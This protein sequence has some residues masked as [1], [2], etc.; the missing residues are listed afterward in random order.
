MTIVRGVARRHNVV[1]EGGDVSQWWS[2]EPIARRAVELL[3]V[4]PGDRVLDLGA[5]TGALSRAVIAA[6][7][8]VTAVELDPKFEDELRAV[9]GDRGSVVIGDVLSVELER[10]DLAITNPPWELD[11]EAR[12]LL[13]GASLARRCAGIVSADAHHTPKRLEGGWRHL[14]EHVVEHCVPRVAYSARGTGQ[15]ETDLVVVSLRS[16]PRASGE[17]DTVQ[18]GTFEWRTPTKRRRALVEGT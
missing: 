4:R 9:V 13:R 14:R 2:P 6:G 12:F 8:I 5:G 7:G 17:H 11:W 1:T 16:R 3:G 15:E 10:H 18:V